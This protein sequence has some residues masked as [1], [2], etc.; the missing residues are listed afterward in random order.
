MC[1]VSSI[2]LNA[3]AISKRSPEPKFSGNLL[4]E[5]ADRVRADSGQH[6]LAIG[7]GV[8]HVGQESFS[9]TA[10]LSLL[11]SLSRS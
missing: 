1:C 2:S 6:R 5:I 4:E 10:N 11:A 3:G 8:E 7:G 9:F